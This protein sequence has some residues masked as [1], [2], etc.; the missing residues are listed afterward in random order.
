MET[1]HVCPDASVCH[2]GGAETLACDPCPLD[3]GERGAGARPARGGGRQGA[4][5]CGVM[6]E[7]FD[8]WGGSLC[9]GDEAF[10]GDALLLGGLASGSVALDATAAARS[11]FAASAEPAAASSG[12]GG[13]T[14]EAVLAAPCW[15]DA[16]P[17]ESDGACSETAVAIAETGAGAA[18]VSESGP[19]RVGSLFAA[20]AE[21]G[22]EGRAPEAE[23]RAP[24]AWQRPSQ[25]SPRRPAPRVSER[26]EDVLLGLLASPSSPGAGAPLSASAR[27]ASS[28]HAARAACRPRHAAELT[29]QDVFDHEASSD[30]CEPWL[31]RRQPADAAAASVTSWRASSS[32]ASPVPRSG[33]A[34]AVASPAAA[35]SPLAPAA[36]AST[37]A[38]TGAASAAT[39][40]APAPP[41]ASAPEA[42]ALGG[43]QGSRPW[44]AAA[45]GFEALAGPLESPPSTSAASCSEAARAQPPCQHQ[46]PVDPDGTLAYT[47]PEASDPADLPT[48]V[49]HEMCTMPYEAFQGSYMLGN[50]GRDT[51]GD[52]A[53][54]T[55]H[56]GWGDQCDTLLYEAGC[57]AGSLAGS[58]PR[59]GGGNQ[60][61]QGD[62]SLTRAHEVC[63]MPYEAFQGSYMLGDQ[64][65]L[66]VGPLSGAAPGRE[67]S[68][69]LYEAAGAGG[70]AL[71]PRYDI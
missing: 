34:A 6:A 63:T 41:A 12:S 11:A 47:R 50:Q 61:D 9:C 66:A 69:L 7:S 55:A 17:A 2:A 32:A 5:A 58:A 39:R 15:G 68:T 56:C 37:P 42:E 60:S 48:Q 20:A 27:K 67:E 13:E 59:P 53:G 54:A 57:A 49:S 30:C 10:D 31:W 16:A 38:P 65:Y 44:P 19:G 24:Q 36:S 21:I 4:P 29:T 1:R 51:E 71:E 35:V 46:D 23:L 14:D 3:A 52:L 8:L 64:G 28:T 26:S 45:L 40:G 43:S 33:F 22:E 18:A 25:R 70:G 62:T